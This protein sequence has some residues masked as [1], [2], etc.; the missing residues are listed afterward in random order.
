MLFSES[1]D[2]MA[3]SHGAAASCL[4]LTHEGELHRYRVPAS[5]GIRAHPHA[6]SGAHAHA[7]TRTRTRTGTIGRA[8]ARARAHTH[9]QTHIIRKHGA[10]PLGQ[11][12]VK[13]QESEDET[14]KL[15]LP[16]VL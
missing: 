2:G 16:V 5:V 14:S 13:I 12:L 7:H 9:T 4:R 8:L 11:A 3:L 1:S 15:N 10:Q 6:H